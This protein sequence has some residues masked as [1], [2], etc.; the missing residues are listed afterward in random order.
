MRKKSGLRK[1]WLRKLLWGA[2][3]AFGL[4]LIVGGIWFFILDRQVTKTFEGRRWTLPA[5]VYAA[6]LEVYAGLARS[7]DDCNLRGRFLDPQFRRAPSAR[8][9]NS[10][11]SA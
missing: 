3:I 4:V 7:R 1:G 2:A 5:Q 9:L 8:R 10:H 6:P 11:A